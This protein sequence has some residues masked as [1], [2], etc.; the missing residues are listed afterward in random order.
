MDH[1]IPL[2]CGGGDAVIN[3]QWLL[4]AM[5]REKA[6][7]ER[8]IYL[9]SGPGADAVLRPLTSPFAGI[10][11]HAFCACPISLVCSKPRGRRLSG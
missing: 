1:V 8:R 11:R 5:W 9:E 2:A 10:L 6:K 4:T 7:W 3:L